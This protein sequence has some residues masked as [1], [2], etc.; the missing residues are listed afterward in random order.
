M[1]NRQL[2]RRFFGCAVGEEFP[3]RFHILVL[4]YRKQYLKAGA[5]QSIVR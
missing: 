5:A 2:A 4:F 3:D 1:P